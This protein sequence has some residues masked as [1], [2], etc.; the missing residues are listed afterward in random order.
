MGLLN[1]IHR[2][3]S[4]QRTANQLRTLSDRTLADIGTTRDD[5]DDYVRKSLNQ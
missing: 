2:M 4:H 3:R 1:N 5:I